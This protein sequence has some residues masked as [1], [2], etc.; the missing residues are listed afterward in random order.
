[1]T[2]DAGAL[3]VGII[4]ALLMGL[5]GILFPMARALRTSAVEAVRAV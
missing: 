1:V 3:L 2:V 5:L 4:A